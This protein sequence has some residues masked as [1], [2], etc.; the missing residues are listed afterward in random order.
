MQQRS[1][2]FA[3]V[4]SSFFGRAVA[5]D[6]PQWGGARR[7][8]VWRE[9]GI[10][11]RLPG[12]LEFKWRTAIGGGYAGPAVADGRVFIADRVLDKDQSN[13]DNPF[14]RGR[15]GGYERIVCLN[16]ATGK[17]AW[18]HEYPCRYEIQYPYGPRATPT[19]HDGKVYAVGAMGDFFCLEATTGR[20]LWSKNYVRD[21]ETEI[22]TWGMSAAPL[23]DG[24]HVIVLAGGKNNACVVT[25]NKDTG[26]EVWRSLYASDPG[27]CPPLIVEAG[28]VRQLIIWNPVGLYSLDPATGRA[29]WQQPFPLKAG[30]SIPTP[31]FDRESRQ[32]FITAFYN[33]PMMMQLD[34][35]SPT[36][37]LLWKGSSDSEMQTDGLHAIMCT[38]VFQDGFIYGVCSYG[39]L[40]CLEARTGKRVWET[41]QPTGKGRWWNAFL[42]PH[43]DR[44]FL[45]NEQGDLIIAKLSPRG[46]EE[47]SRAFLIAPTNP[48]QRRQVVWSHPAFAGRCV[49]AR[50]DK[51][52]VCVNLADK[53]V[54]RP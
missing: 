42:I 19:V 18:K 15:I 38:P 33:G 41:T 26:E 52:I 23:I 54:A 13:P 25:L 22:N 44:H 31:I 4:V 16:A 12:K 37:R 21:F 32:L 28:N 29:Y 34:A 10:V 11:S 50:N 24:G 20:V 17:V 51:E 2:V 40:R 30:L 46:Y 36:A 14:Q 48:A 47:I 5:D 1:V 43:E 27:Y 8:G 49:F 3:V 9:T 53:S 39:Q 6:W 7:D 45:F 35:A